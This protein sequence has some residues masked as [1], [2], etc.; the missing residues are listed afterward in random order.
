MTVKELIIELLQ[1][2][3]EANVIVHNRV[4]FQSFDTLYKPDEH[5]SYANG[6]LTIYNDTDG[7]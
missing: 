5:L 7:S 3:S 2:P 1:Y 4:Q 6:R